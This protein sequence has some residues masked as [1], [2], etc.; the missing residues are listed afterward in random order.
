MWNLSKPHT[1][2]EHC[3]LITPEEAKAEIFVV[4]EAQGCSRLSLSL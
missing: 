2:G 4:V 1:A 3:F